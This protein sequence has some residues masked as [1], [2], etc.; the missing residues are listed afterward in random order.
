MKFLW[1]ILW[2]ALACACGERQEVRQSKTTPQI[3]TP[4]TVQTTPEA[5]KLL[6]EWSTTIINKDAARVNNITL[7]VGAVNGKR[8]LSG[9]VFSFNETIGKRT[10]EKGYQEADMFVGEE[11]VK[12][13][14]GGVCQLSG[15]MYMAVR[16]AGLSV[17]ERHAHSQKVAYAAEGEDACVNYGTKDFCFVNTAEKTIEVQAYTDGSSVSVRIYECDV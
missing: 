9:E 13:Y 15:T 1:I 7:A 17:T 10:A 11:T 4:Q 3:E 14:G 2:L 16:Q 8:L 5:P 12:A 6:G